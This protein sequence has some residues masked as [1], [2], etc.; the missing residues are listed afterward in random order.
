MSASLKQLTTYAPATVKRKRTRIYDI[1]LVIT[2]G[3]RV[4]VTAI[5]G[6][7]AVKRFCSNTVLLSEFHLWS[8]YVVSDYRGRRSKRA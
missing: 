7:Y 8:K 4:Q 5:R 2:K 3:Y 6:P 1:E